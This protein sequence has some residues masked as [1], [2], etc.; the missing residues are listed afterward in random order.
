MTTPAPDGDASGVAA[1]VGGIVAV[2]KSAAHAGGDGGSA[3]ADA[4]DLL[5]QRVSGG[6]QKG[7]GSSEGNVVGTGETPLGSAEVAPWKAE[8]TD[9]DGGWQSKAEAALAHADIAGA[10]ELWVLHSQSS[11][12]WTSPAS[13]GDSESDGAEVSALDMLDVKVLHSEAHSSGK[14]SSALLVVN[15]T[16]IATSDDANGSCEIDASPL[17]DLL[18]LTATGGTDTATDVTTAGADVATADIGDG[19]LG[20]TVVGTS[21]QGGTAATPATRTPRTAHRSNP[22]RGALPHT[23]GPAPGAGLPFTGADAGRMA[24]TAVALAVLGA[25]MTAFGRRRRMLAP[26]G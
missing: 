4:V 20:G 1:E 25:A 17:L 12:T 6:D 18:C 11:A 26:L 2:G 7:S 23:T 24:A 3:S 22:P 15:G 9:K 21:T 10:A 5:G 13:T 14:S 16:G 8:V 19:A